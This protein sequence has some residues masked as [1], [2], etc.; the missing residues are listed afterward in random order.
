MSATPAL[1]NAP[2]RSIWPLLAG[3]MSGIAVAAVAAVAA[4]YCLPSPKTLP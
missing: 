2:S 4:A 3:D 1:L